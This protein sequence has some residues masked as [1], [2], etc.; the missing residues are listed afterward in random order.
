MATNL[1][2]FQTLNLRPDETKLF[3]AILLVCGY[4][5]VPHYKMYWEQSSDCNNKVISEAMSRNRSCLTHKC[6]INII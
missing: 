6:V 5:Q 4:C 3:V 1:Y 2:S